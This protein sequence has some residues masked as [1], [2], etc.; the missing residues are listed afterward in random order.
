MEEGLELLSSVN[1]KCYSVFRGKIFLRILLDMDGITADFFGPL[2]HEYQRRTG[3]SVPIERITEWDM[4]KNVSHPE[5]IFAI[6]H[7]HG[8]FENLPPVPGAIEAIKR[9][10]EL[11]HEVVIVS[12]PCTPHSAA[13][14]IKWCAKHLPFM[15]QKNLILC[16]HKY[17]YTISGDV[18]VDDN[19]ET[20]SR[21][22]QENKN[23]IALTIAYNY[24][25]ITPNPY[26]L[27]AEGTPES[28]WKQI[29][30]VI[31]NRPLSSRQNSNL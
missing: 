17:K 5:T 15:D 31:E 8:F 9:F 25:K 2:L 10:L 3:E 30:D 20:A 21:Y 19:A 29:V 28:C 27:R 6:F 22:T 13:E 14:K 16:H 1:K 4:G 23:S 11:G 12:A 24:N 7:E 18:I 26:T